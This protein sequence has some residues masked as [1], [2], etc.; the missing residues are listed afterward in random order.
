MTEAVAFHYFEYL[1][2]HKDFSFQ[3]TLSMYVVLQAGEACWCERSQSW[4]RSPQY[5]TVPSEFGG[6]ANTWSRTK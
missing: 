1:L 4:S 6:Q 2:S 3:L 5:T